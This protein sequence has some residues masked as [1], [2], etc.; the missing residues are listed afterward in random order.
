[1]V[2]KLI[3]LALLISMTSGVTA[4]SAVADA[5]KPGQSMTHMKTE[6]GISA[7]LE[8]AGV[9]LYV[10]GGATAAVMGDSISSAEGQVVFHIPVTGTKTGVEH[11]GSNIV[12]FNTSNNSQILIKNPLIDLKAGVVKAV[13]P[14]ASADAVTLFT[15]TN[16]KDLKAKITNDKKSKLRTTAY[17]GAK[18]ALAPGLAASISSL[19]GLPV[20]SL[21]DE[22]AFASA[23]VSLYSVIK[24]R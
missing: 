6:K 18:L 14:Q 9:V 16:A 12:L 23:N 17:D 19:L 10:Q 4:T 20:G 1:M 13:I 21:P 22:L 15:I 5:A 3:G 24:N 8:A 11:T 2:K 7:T